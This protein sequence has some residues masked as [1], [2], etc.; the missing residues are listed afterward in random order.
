[1]ASLN[2]T[3]KGKCETVGLERVA[4]SPQPHSI[5]SALSRSLPSCL[6]CAAFRVTQAL[7][8]PCMLII[9]QASSG[10]LSSNY[11]VRK[12]N[13]EILYCQSIINGLFPALNLSGI[14]FIWE[15]NSEHLLNLQMS[16]HKKSKSTYV[17]FAE[18]W[19]IQTVR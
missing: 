5:T 13:S 15:T 3:K 2:A 1:M 8:V 19:E 18:I 11:Q 7:Q 12:Q 17:L 14:L 16:C 6:R 4:Q 10:C 9:N